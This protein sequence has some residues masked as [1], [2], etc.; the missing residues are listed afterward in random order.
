MPESSRLQLLEMFS[1][2]N[3]ALSDTAD[4]FSGSLNKGGTA[5]FPF[6]LPIP[7]FPDYLSRLPIR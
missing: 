4:N 7:L 3:F 5:D 6:I 1:E 2:N